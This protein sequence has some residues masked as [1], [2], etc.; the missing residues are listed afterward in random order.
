M[1]PMLKITIRV[2]FELKLGSEIAQQGEYNE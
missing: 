2:V 1:A